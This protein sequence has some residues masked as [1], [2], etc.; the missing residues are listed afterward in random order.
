MGKPAKRTNPL[1]ARSLRIKKSRRMQRDRT[2]PSWFDRVRAI[3]FKED[4]DV[5]ADDFDEDL[6]ELEDKAD[7][8]T[9]PD[10]SDRSYDGSDADH[11]YELKG[12]REERKQEKL[13]ERIAKDRARQMESAK[14]EEVRAAYQSLLKAENE[15]KT[16]LVEALVGQGFKL[17]CSNHVEHF[18][19]DLYATKRVDFYYLDTVGHLSPDEHKHETNMLYGDIYLNARSNCSFGPFRPPQR[20][21]RKAVRV[22]SC[23]GEYELSFQFIGNGYLKLRVT[24]E[25]VFMNP[26]TNR[27]RAPPPNVPGVFEFVGIW[28]DREREK[29]ERQEWLKA[30]RSPSPRESWF[31]MNHPMGWYHEGRFF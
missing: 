21:S 8:D 5:T 20:A 29:A 18:Y 22:K 16:I 31:E 27:P 9:D 30:H 10:D 1:G 28:R 19:S 17:F 23:D 4:R 24:Q 3:S 25:M 2:I 7:G 13:Q 14:E 6:S 15:H 26:Y 12:E 11:Y